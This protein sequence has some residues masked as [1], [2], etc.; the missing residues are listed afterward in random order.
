MKNIHVVPTDKD[1][2]NFPFI[3]KNCFTDKYTIINSTFKDN[4]ELIG[5]NI[6]ITS[7]EEIKDGDWFYE[8]INKSILKYDSKSNELILIKAVF[9]GFCNKIIL[10]TDLE[11][12]ANGVQAID[13][14]FLEWF[15]KN[16]SCEFVEVTTFFSGI[17]YPYEI[18]IPQEESKQE[19]CCTP[20]G[21]IKRYVDCVGCDRKPKQE[22]NFYEK[23]KEYFE[24]TPREKVLED[25]AKS[26]EFDN[27]SIG[28][29][30]DEVAEKES[31]SR[32]PVLTHRNPSDSP[33]VGSKQTFKH[34]VIFGYIFAKERS[35][36]LDEIKTAMKNGYGIKYF[37]EHKFLKNLNNLKK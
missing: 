3:A 25:W 21:Q 27:V 5:Y 13:D 26:A 19:N 20:I 8:S 11:L 4:C 28:G 18:I 2:L 23:L 16:L 30:V 31:E 37:S 34:G 35:Y 1:K 22:P 6:Y 14:E 29:T 36:S 17:D 7:D 10:T 33:Y 15:I 32:Y 9:S 12:I 24:N